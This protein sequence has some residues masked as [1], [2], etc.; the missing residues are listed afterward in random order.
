MTVA[1]AE[2]WVKEAVARVFV[3]EPEPH[4]RRNV[5][6]ERYPGLSDDSAHRNV[7]L[8]VSMSASL[9]YALI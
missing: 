6:R 8:I 4:G 5:L 3:R 1:Q 2:G 9:S 7:R